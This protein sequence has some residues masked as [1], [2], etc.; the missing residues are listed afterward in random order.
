MTSTT[1]DDFTNLEALTETKL[2]EFA[3]DYDLDELT[4]NDRLSLIELART[5]AR[6]D[7]YNSLFSRLFNA[8]L[9]DGSVDMKKLEMLQKFSDAALTSASKLQSDLKIVR[10]DR[11]SNEASIEDYIKDLKD[12]A[13]KFLS[14]RLSYIYCPKC[15]TLISTVWLLNYAAGSRFKYVCPHCNEE[16]IVTDIELENRTNDETKIV[17]TRPD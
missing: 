6:L 1:D 2:K 12:R 9:E 8:A 17:P 7:I 11:K 14:S 15:S 13:K 5:L 16:F 4:S 3:Q 10:K